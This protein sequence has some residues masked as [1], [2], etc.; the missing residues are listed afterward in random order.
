MHLPFV[1]RKQ[2]VLGRM[3]L[4]YICLLESGIENLQN[5][6]SVGF[7]CLLILGLNL[8]FLDFILFQYI[9]GQIL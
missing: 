9:L 4:I 2:I 8:L 6:L 5:P 7:H 3:G 1:I